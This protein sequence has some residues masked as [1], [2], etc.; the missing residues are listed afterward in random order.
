MSK[1]SL[2]LIRCSSDARPVLRGRRH[3]GFRP[4]II[5]GGA[6]AGYLPT[7]F[8]FPILD[9]RLQI[10]YQN[11]LALVLAGLT[12]VS[13]PALRYIDPNMT[14]PL[15]VDLNN[16]IAPNADLATAAQMDV[17]RNPDN[18]ASTVRGLR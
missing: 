17:C 4:H 8:S 9:A 16:L 6:I 18:S 7:A 3:Q 12:I 5:Q 2:R 11:Y 14:G 10:S 13:W 15:T 1:P